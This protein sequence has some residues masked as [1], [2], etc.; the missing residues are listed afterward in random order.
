MQE[1][2]KRR[3]K[4]ADSEEYATTGP[5]SSIF[6]GPTARL[7]AQAYIVG[8]SEQTISML[9]ESANLSY[10]TTKDALKKLV[11]MGFVVPT[12]KIGNAQAYKFHLEN[13]MSSL[14]ACGAQFQKERKDL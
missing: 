14:L 7:F 4:R 12:R 5:F 2:Q 1:I 11:D 6:G 8:N 3:G 13:H 10:K 9:S